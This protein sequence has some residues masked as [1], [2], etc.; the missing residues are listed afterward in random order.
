MFVI[1]VQNPVAFE[2]LGF[3]IYWYGIIMALAILVAMLVGNKLY[4]VVNP[5]IR[6]DIIVEYAPMIIISGIIGARLYFCALHYDYYFS[7]PLEI[8]DLRQGGLSIHGAILF[9]V[10]GMYAVAKR[11]GIPL[12]C[13]MDAMACGTMLGQFIGR[14]GNYFNSEAYGLPVASQTWGLFIPE[15]RRVSEY[16]NYSLFHPTFLYESLLDLAGFCLLAVIICKAG[17]KYRGLSF[18]TYLCVYSV[19]R[20]FIERIRID[21][22]LNIAGGVPIAEVISLVLLLIGVCGIFY[23]LVKAARTKN[24]K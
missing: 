22:A 18:F 9:G 4:N 6:R 12:L 8:F 7:S 2:F 5:T 24:F 17:Q 21:S 23:T 1:P 10:L 20:F 16:A 3:P 19:I 13:I 14:W 11:S 15:A